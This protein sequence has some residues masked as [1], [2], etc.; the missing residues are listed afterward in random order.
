VKSRKEEEETKRIVRKGRGK[1]SRGALK[2]LMIQ[3][4]RVSSE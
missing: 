1:N 3:N 2:R 4:T